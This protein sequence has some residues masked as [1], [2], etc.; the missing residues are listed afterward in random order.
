MAASIK[1]F[2]CTVLRGIGWINFFKWLVLHLPCMVVC[3][4]RLWGQEWWLPVWCVH[5]PLLFCWKE[6]Y[7]IPTVI[8]LTVLSQGSVGQCFVLHGTLQIYQHAFISKQNTKFR[9]SGASSRC[10]LHFWSFG[11]GVVKLKWQSLRRK[12]SCEHG[13]WTVVGGW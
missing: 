11:D 6:Q 4:R 13:D 5:V 12:G 9:N 1:I 3:H 2:V 10:T 7:V 8:H